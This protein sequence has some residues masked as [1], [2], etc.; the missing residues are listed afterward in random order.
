MVGVTPYVLRHTAAV[1][2]AEAGRPMEEIAQFMGHTSPAVTFRTYARYSPD[3]LRRASDAISTRLSGSL[4]LEAGPK[5]NEQSTKS[6][7]ESGNDH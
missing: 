1:W 2:L 6:E 4:N 3:Y 5:V 7:N